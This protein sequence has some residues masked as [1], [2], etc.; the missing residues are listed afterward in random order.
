MDV[1]SVLDT[2]SNERNKKTIISKIIGRVGPTSN[3]CQW[4]LRDETDFHPHPMVDGG[5]GPTSNLIQWLFRGVTH[6]QHHPMVVEGRD[7]LPTEP[8]GSWGMGPTSRA[9]GW[10]SSHWTLLAR[11]VNLF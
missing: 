7:P 2:G 1:G 4:M 5:V 10:C 9:L 3:H 11:T 8:N 6:L